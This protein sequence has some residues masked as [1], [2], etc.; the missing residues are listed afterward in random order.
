MGRRHTGLVE[1]NTECSK[2][3]DTCGGRTEMCPSFFP[4]CP[5][6]DKRMSDKLFKEH[7]S[8]PLV[9][10]PCT[11]YGELGVSCWSLSCTH[12]VRFLCVHGLW[13]GL[14]GERRA[15]TWAVFLAPARRL[16]CCGLKVSPWTCA[17]VDIC[18]LS[19]NL[20]TTCASLWNPS[21]DIH[22]LSQ[23]FCV[24]RCAIKTNVNVGFHELSHG[25]L[26]SRL[27]S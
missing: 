15:G 9:L 21:V 16:A 27:W 20:S 2:W 18:V 5:M 11:L 23:L 12:Q 4:I 17:C 25:D 26:S 1:A 14:V 7:N 8:S 13:S 22:V 6:I 10:E 3:S 24:P 19:L